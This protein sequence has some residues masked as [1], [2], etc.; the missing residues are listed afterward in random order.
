MYV[1]IM[2]VKYSLEITAYL[3]NQKRYAN[4]AIVH[5]NKKST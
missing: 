5:V 2:N 4:C 1:G 3:Q